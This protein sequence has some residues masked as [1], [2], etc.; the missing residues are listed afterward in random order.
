MLGDGSHQDQKVTNQTCRVE[1]GTLAGASAT[2]CETVWF[3]SQRTLKS[4]LLDA[5][6]EEWCG[7]CFL[8]PDFV[9]AFGIGSFVP[10]LLSDGN[11]L[12]SLFCHPRLQPQAGPRPFLNPGL[13][14][15]HL[16]RK[17]SPPCHKVAP[18]GRRHVAEWPVSALLT[19]S[20][21][22]WQSTHRRIWALWEERP[23]GAGSDGWSSV[24]CLEAQGPTLCQGTSLPS[25][26]WSLP[27]C[28]LGREA[29]KGTGLLQCQGVGSFLTPY[30]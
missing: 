3:L 18:G 1:G 17:P 15:Q 10:R 28:E 13:M 6:W 14:M 16:P 2:L 4:V 27:G 12:L 8:F 9:G 23:W 26:P 25:V 19:V 30:F 24:V 21:S 11:P 22:G 20:H 7:T 5:A 29:A